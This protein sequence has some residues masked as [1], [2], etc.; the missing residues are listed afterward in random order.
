MGNGGCCCYSTSSDKP[1][2]RQA[3]LQECRQNKFPDQRPILAL[4]KY[5]ISNSSNRFMKY[6]FHWSWKVFD[7]Q[8]E[9]FWRA[10]SLSDH[11]AWVRLWNLLNYEKSFEEKYGEFD[12]N[13]ARETFR[14]TW[15]PSEDRNKFGNFDGRTVLMRMDSSEKMSFL[16]QIRASSAVHKFKF[17]ICSMAIVLS[18]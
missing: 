10:D 12:V 18:R 9:R 3:D 17:I 5:F 14:F 1:I 4:P 16:V 7:F 13:Q 8:A 2:Y 11:L 15:G 6:W